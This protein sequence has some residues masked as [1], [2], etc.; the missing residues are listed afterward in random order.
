[1]SNAPSSSDDVSS[2]SEASQETEMTTQ[3]TSA[4]PSQ[5][6]LEDPSNP[7]YL[8]HADN[9]GNILVSQLLTVISW[10]LN[11]VSKEISA[12]ILYDELA[13]EIWRDLRVRFQR[14]NGPHIFNLRKELMNLK[15][16]VQS[17][18]IYYTRLKT[19]WEELTTYRPSCTCNNCSC[20][21]VK[22]LQEHHHMEYIMSFL[23]GLTDSYSQVRSNILLMDPL[24]DL[25]RVFHL[26]SQEENQRGTAPPNASVL[27]PSMAFA[28]TGNKSS[29]QRFDSHASRSF[30]PCKNRPFCTHCN[31]LGH[32]IEKC[33]KLHGYPPGYNKPKQ[34][35]EASANQFQTS[36]DTPSSIQE[37]NT[38]LPQLNPTQYQQLLNLLAANSPGMTSLDPSSS[39]SN[40]GPNHQEDDW[41]RQA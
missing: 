7:Y 22:K 29:N 8:H 16:D 25:S 33:Y 14:S 34:Q 32:T 9:P 19:I 21:G 6:P 10:I 30:P 31:V 23:M 15:Q 4:A 17:V 1:M 37:H 27:S 11:S 2:A 18:S 13:A 39:S 26:V 5:T 35:K 12:S 40:S 41:N 28:F 24:P 36:E 20:G 38:F 3:P